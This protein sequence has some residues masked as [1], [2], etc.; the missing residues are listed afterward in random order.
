MP[1][2]LPNEP[3]EIPGPPDG[4]VFDQLPGK[5]LSL[6]KSQTLK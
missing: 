5:L 3:T 4:A 2:A 6:D 1:T